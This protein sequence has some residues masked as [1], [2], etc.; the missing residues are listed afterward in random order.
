[1]ICDKQGTSYAT[2]IVSGI[3]AL[4]MQAQP[5][6]VNQ[7]EAVKALL[8]ATAVHNIEGVGNIPWGFTRDEQ[9]LRDGAGA[10]NADLACQ[11]ARGINGN[12]GTQQYFSNAQNPLTLASPYLR[13]GQRVRA[14]IAWANNPEGQVVLRMKCMPGPPSSVDGRIPSC[15]QASPARQ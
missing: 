8:M 2:P 1:V 13:T 7:P 12:W 11:V 15:G 6:L 10:V 3:A 4:L 5:S 9:D 14:V